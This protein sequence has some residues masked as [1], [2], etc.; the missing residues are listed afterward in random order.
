MAPIEQEQN[1]DTVRQYAVWLEG[2]VKELHKKLEKFEE[3]DASQ[4]QGWLD[5][6]MRDQFHR[7]RKKFFGFGRETLKKKN[8][9]V[10][11][12]QQKLNLHTK[13]VTQEA[14]DSKKHNEI[15]E[16]DNEKAPLVKEHDFKREKLQEETDIRG[17]IV[18]AEDAWQKMN[19]LYQESTEITVTER[20]Y[21]KVVHRQAK[22]KLKDE[23]NDTGKE[24]IITAPGPAKLKPGC[25]YSID[26]AVATA[27][28]KYQY[29]L[30]LERQR[31]RMEEA[32]FST[33]VKT[34]YRLCEYLA[35]HGDKVLP[36]I[37]EEILSDF[38]AAHL[39]ESRWRLFDTETTGYMW[40]LS[41]RAGSYFQFEPTRSGKIPEEM[42]KGHQ[43]SVLTDG[44]GGYNPVKKNPNIRLGQCWSHARRE[45]FERLEDYPTQCEQAIAI[46]DRL[47]EIEAKAETFEELGRLRATESKSTI[48]ELREWCFKTR[49]QFLNDEGISKAIDYTL[50]FW[51][52]L[53]LF[54]KDLSVPLSNN[55]AE[56][57]L[58]G[59][60]LGRKNFNGSKTING[61]DTA[62][63]LY[64][65]IETSKKVS[66]HPAEYL[67]YLVTENW[68]GRA[69]LTPKLFGWEVLGLKPNTEITWPKK[70]EW[71]INGE[72]EKD[73]K[74]A[75]T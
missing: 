60:I 1:I 58:R 41:N 12:H 24:V 21:Q 32:G 53:T 46:I 14:E 15:N 52:E 44:Y 2:T 42:L 69:P 54:L 49:P 65:L 38:C 39:D 40:I 25:K 35:E 4:R 56:R 29:H 43:G 55:D 72:K 63:T 50:K 59:P 67:K 13:R 47:F 57:G 73:P 20:V 16:Q 8:R 19:G 45:F 34:L 11:H 7:L 66:V 33:D 51:K 5:E 22:Y 61:A 3:A 23:F 17:L 70:S 64:T 31:R 74:K 37:R 28:D 18:G 48:D 75:R 6:A 26:F 10:G 71:K 30:P 36:A 27:I 68:Y 62:A 9:Q